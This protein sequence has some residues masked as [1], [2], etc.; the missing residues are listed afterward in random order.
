MSKALIGILLT[1]IAFSAGYCTRQNT[2]PRV[3]VDTLALFTAWQDT[4]PRLV[5]HDTVYVKAFYHQSQKEKIKMQ[6]RI[7]P[8]PQP[9]QDELLPRYYS[10]SERF[11]GGLT[12]HWDALTY[13][14][15]NSMNTRISRQ[16]S[17][18]I[19]YIP[20][21]VLRPKPTPV[22]SHLYLTAGLHGNRQRVGT[23]IGFSVVRERRIWGVT[24]DPLQHY[25]GIQAG[26]RLFKY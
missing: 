10:G 14:Y 2:H 5:K 20:R 7:A 6:E 23:P 9:C 25:I 3:S 15:L 16:D 19:I 18:Q 4:L 12:I 21:Y 11:P 26:V 24:Y 1:L 13:G 17:T 22:K 8:L